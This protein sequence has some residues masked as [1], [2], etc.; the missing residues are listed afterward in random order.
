MNPR[1]SQL[2]TRDQFREAVF[3]RDKHRCVACGRPAQDAHHILD[4]KLWPDGGY[5]LDNGASLCGSSK[6]SYIEDGKGFESTPGSGEGCHM[7]AETTE[8]SAEE[9]RRLAKI[10]T[11][12]LPP[13]LSADES[14]DKWSNV[15]LLDGSRLPGEM[16]WDPPVQEILKPYLHL[17]SPYTKAPRTYHLPWSPGAT[18]DDLLMGD[19]SY[20]HGKEVVVTAKQDG[21]GVSIYGPEGYIHARKVALINTP[22]SGRVKALAAEIGRDIPPG[23][24]ICGESLVRTHTIHYEHLMPHAR[25]FLQVFNIWAERNQC[26]SWDEVT[27]WTL[28][29]DL[30][31]VPVLYRGPWD[32]KIVRAQWKPMFQGDPMEGYVV[33]LA[34][35]F[36]LRDYHKAVG[37]FVRE[38]FHGVTDPAAPK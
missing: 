7:K 32:E 15:V 3:A 1:R 12:L 30:P 27:E 18:S 10:E 33:R 20:F 29:L 38:K 14:Y 36:P 8:L 11:V 22:D 13:H 4:R 37:K 35:G 16:F 23:Y 2:L 5:Y 28:L 26:L 17:F 21:E 24:R 25:W 34:E 31:T 9:V 19:T 6:D